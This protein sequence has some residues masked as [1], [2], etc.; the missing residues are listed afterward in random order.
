MKE[1]YLMWTHASAMPY[2]GI[3]YFTYCRTRRS[4]IQTLRLLD[5]EKVRQQINRIVVSS[6]NEMQ[7]HFGLV[8]TGEL[9]EALGKIGEK[10]DY[11]IIILPHSD[12]FGKYL[13]V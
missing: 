10:W 7:W 4:F 13:L 12:E 3:T 2:S 11:E 8:K 1:T 9:L 6:F 5:N